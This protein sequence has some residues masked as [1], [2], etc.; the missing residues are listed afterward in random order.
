[1]LYSS[2]PDEQTESQQ[3]IIEI[4]VAGSKKIIFKL[5]ICKFTP[6]PLSLFL[7]AKHNKI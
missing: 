5:K 7:H 1:M 4:T 3:S 6:V 2:I